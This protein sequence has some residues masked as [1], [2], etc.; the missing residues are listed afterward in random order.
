MKDLKLMCS[1]LED[2]DEIFQIDS[3]ILSYLRFTGISD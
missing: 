3:V 2:T 1:M